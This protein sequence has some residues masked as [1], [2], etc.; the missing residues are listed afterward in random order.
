MN[1]TFNNTNGWGNT[2]APQ[3]QQPPARQR[4]DSGM[5]SGTTNS[6]RHRRQ[7]QFQFSNKSME[8]IWQGKAGEE[9]LS[10]PPLPSVVSLQHT[11]MATPHDSGYISALDDS[12][13]WGAHDHSMG[14][15]YDGDY[16]D[17][18]DDPKG[19]DNSP[20]AQLQQRKVA[21]KGNATTERR[22]RK[23]GG[24]RPPKASSSGG[25]VRQSKKASR[26]DK[27]SS[28]NQNGQR[29][30]PKKPEPTTG[31]VPVYLPKEL[32]LDNATEGNLVVSGWVAVSIGSSLEERFHHGSKRI[33]AK[34]IMYLRI[35]DVFDGA[36]I[37]LHK[38][39]EGNQI[40]HE[41]HL[42]R[43]WMCSSREISSRIGRC[44]HIASRSNPAFCI[45]DLLP[46][47][48]DE[49]FFPE[50]KQLVSAQQFAK[51][52]DRLFVAGKGK[53]YAPDEQHDAAMYIMFSLDA[54]IKNC[55]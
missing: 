1:N 7:R 9:Q 12:E 54:L 20:F 43:D 39:C 33:D 51:Q 34:D 24:D 23:G 19:E 28:G 13:D 47:S 16:D 15:Y 21:R 53:V 32:R 3:P 2:L 46:V 27:T 22:R 26:D 50:K 37:F 30:P 11:H 44:V 48:L 55:L 8:Q 31:M 36:I 42:R 35:V 45:A 17:D 18:D 38:S 25:A 49:S 29:P 5:Y 52:H 41:L 14:S 10:L 6:S 4:I 40:Q